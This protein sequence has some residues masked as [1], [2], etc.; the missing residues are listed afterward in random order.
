V[1]LNKRS[2]VAI[3]KESGAFKGLE[4]TL[5]SMLIGPFQEE[6]YYSWTGMDERDERTAELWGDC[7]LLL[8][9]IIKD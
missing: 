9:E 5:F 7:Y 4:Q 2:L 1:K 8:S 3:E 6:S